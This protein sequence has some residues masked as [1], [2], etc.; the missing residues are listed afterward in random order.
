MADVNM[1]IINKA[2]LDNN[3]KDNIDTLKSGVKRFS[4]LFYDEKE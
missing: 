1:Y 4:I 3:T 2:M